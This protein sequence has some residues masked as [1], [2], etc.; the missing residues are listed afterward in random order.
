[1]TDTGPTRT[2][3][4]TRLLLASLKLGCIGFGG[5]M[6]VLAMMRHEFVVKRKVCDE[7]CFM[8]AAALSQALP[9]A[10]S[11]N[12]MS[13]LGLS[14]QGFWGATL[15][16]WGFML[17][18]FLLMIALSMAYETLSKLEFATRMMHGMVAGVVGI[19]VAVAWDLAGHSATRCRRGWIIVVLSFVATL[20]GVGVVE[21]VLGCGVAGMFLCASGRGKDGDG[22]SCAAGAAAGWSLKS[23]APLLLGTAGGLAVLWPLALLFLRVGLVTFGGGFVMIPM[24]QHEVVS[25]HQWL[26]AKEFADGMALGQLTPGPVVITATFVGYKVAGLLGA[27]VASTAVFL[28]SFVLSLVF[29]YSLDR[30]K[31]NPGVAAFMTGVQPAVVGLMG[32][33]AILLGRA[34]LHHWATIGIAA[35]SALLLIRFKLNPVVIILGTGLLGLLL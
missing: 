27:W 32:G 20:L 30:W 31:T 1:M 13:F 25:G 4:K 3:S 28:P 18:S 11:F 19:I 35:L 17:P 29:G 12:A 2:I 21:I 7:E 33:A 22:P 15:A 34:G 9:G 14:V 6:A 24:I 8:N 5:G 26:T 16:S 23:Y 10:I